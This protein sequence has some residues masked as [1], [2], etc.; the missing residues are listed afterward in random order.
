MLKKR[1]LLLNIGRPLIISILILM[2]WYRG[3]WAYNSLIWPYRSHGCAEFIIWSTAIAAEFTLARQAE[4]CLLE[5]VSWCADLQNIGPFA[6]DH[7]HRR[8]LEELIHVENTYRWRIFALEEMEIIRHSFMN[9]MSFSLTGNSIK[10]VS[11]PS[12]TE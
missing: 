6:Y 8:R 3:N 9:D 2:A 12:S 5:W 11:Y 1:S 4:S 10:R 7:I